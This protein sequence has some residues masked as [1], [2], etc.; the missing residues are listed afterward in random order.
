MLAVFYWRGTW[1]DV[2]IQP[3]DY[4]D[5][6]VDNAMRTLVIE[7]DFIPILNDFKEIYL[8]ENIR[9]ILMVSELVVSLVTLFYRKTETGLLKKAPRKS[10]PGAF[11][12]WSYLDCYCTL[13]LAFYAILNNF[14]RKC[15]MLSEYVRQLYR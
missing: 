3:F 14:H 8:C 5:G 4:G 6:N 10:A 15:E 9:I 7:W 13:L 12:L 1:E 2:P 11:L